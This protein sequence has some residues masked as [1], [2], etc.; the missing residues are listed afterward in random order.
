MNET[1]IRLKDIIGL[2][3]DE[4]EH[5][6]EEA[7]W[8]VGVLKERVAFFAAANNGHDVPYDKAAE[9]LANEH[10]RGLLANVLAGSR[11]N[12]A[13]IKEVVIDINNLDKT[14][15]VVISTP[16]KFAEFRELFG[17]TGEA[18]IYVC[19]AHSC[20]D[21]LIDGGQRVDE[22]YVDRITELRVSIAKRIAKFVKE[23]K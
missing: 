19:D 15:E 4:I 21:L 16:K 8:D 6:R 18:T 11:T 2:G 13:A 23:G 12:E 3:T 20:Y 9:R 5:L 22:A 14:P 17:E 7:E 1:I 10:A